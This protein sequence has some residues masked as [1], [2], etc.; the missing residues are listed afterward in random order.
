VG[1]LAGETDRGGIL[2]PETG[3]LLGFGRLGPRLFLGEEVGGVALLY[4]AEALVE[5]LFCPLARQHLDGPV[6]HV[7]SVEFAH[8]AHVVVAFAEA[9]EAVAE[10]LRR[11][12][13]PNDLALLEARVLLEGAGEYII[14]DFVTQ[15]AAVN[16]EIVL[17][18]VGERLVDPLLLAN[19]AEHLQIVLRLLVHTLYLN[20]RLV[21]GGQLLSR[22]L[23]VT[24]FQQTWLRVRM[25]A[26]LGEALRMLA[27][28][29]SVRSNFGGGLG[30]RL[31]RSLENLTID[32]IKV[33]V[34]I[35][36]ASKR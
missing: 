33:V 2:T 15:I 29:G 25:T 10:A 18:P 28:L 19:F 30:L 32:Q 3:D 20:V 22:L 17:G 35:H 27:F 14:G 31:G 23:E 24:L 4:N 26:F 16:S 1:I 36:K 7:L 34:V 5:R 13:V 8:G 12:L 11:L 6:A 21:R 9:D